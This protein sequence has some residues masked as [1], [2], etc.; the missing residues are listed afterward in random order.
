MDAENSE[1]ENKSKK[2]YGKRSTKQWVL[3][4]V[5]AAII[6]YGLIYFLFIRKSGTGTGGGIGY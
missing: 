3:I 5:V 2:G 4:Y 1:P 6:V